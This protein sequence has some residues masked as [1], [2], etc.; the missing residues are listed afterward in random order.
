STAAATTRIRSTWAI[1]ASLS[2]RGRVAS[3]DCGALL[4][5]CPVGYCAA[6]AAERRGSIAVLLV[7]AAA[8][9]ALSVVAAPTAMILAAAVPA[10][11]WTVVLLAI[12][13]RPP[14]PSFAML[15]W[16]SGVAVP[17]ALVVNDWLQAGGDR[18]VVA[19]LAAPVVE[20]TAKGSALVALVLL[21]PEELRD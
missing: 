8:G 11:C 14:G 16:G 17:L 4:R 10:P 2:R 13:R 15:L 12:G 20:E 6:M 9:T 7:P 19:G 1:T 21:L 18:E 3:M 5:R